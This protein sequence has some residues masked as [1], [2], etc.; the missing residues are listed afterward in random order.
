MYYI[1]K[2]ENLI[3]H[4]IYIGLTNNIARRRMRHFTDL[5]C[6][7][8]D[9]HFLQKEFNIYGEENFN[10]CVEF[11]G[12]I[13]SFQIGELE[14]KYITIYDSYKNGYNQNEGGNF[15]PSNGGSQLIQSDIFNILSVLEFM[16]KPGQVLANIFGVSRT[17]IS[18]I[19]RGENH[20]QY[21]K[22]YEKM[23]LEERRK[24]YQIFCDSYNFYEQKATTTIIKGKR[25]L[26][27]KQVHLILINEE[28]KILPRTK[29]AKKVGVASANTLICIIKGKSYQDF[30]LSY[31]KLTEEQKNNLASQLSN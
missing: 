30:S 17:T 4:K 25:K 18:R 12:D 19:K 8:H 22:E 28:K 2:I 27:E 24:I 5:R 13:D 10:F 1:Y 15:G 6:N 21:K 7:R 11:E 23:S 3:N 31:Q 20:N 26:N 16:S 29:M 9:N 14:K